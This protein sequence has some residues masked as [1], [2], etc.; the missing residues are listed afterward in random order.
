MP[1]KNGLQL[2]PETRRKIEVKVPG[3]NRTVYAGIAVL[4]LVVAA[5]AGLY[6]FGNS[7]GN[8]II[9]LD[10][11]LNNL[12]NQRDKKAEANLLVLDKQLS[13]ISVLLN[14]HIYWSK[15]MAKVESLLQGQV[16]FENLAAATPDSKF[17]FKALAAN[18]TTIARQIAAFMSDES[19]KDVVLNNVNTLTN[20]KL[21]FNMQI[22]F[23]K[24]K[25]LK[26]K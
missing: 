24:A 8:K 14:D 1:D 25:F 17:D 4:V 26:Q 19:I 21:E 6:F 13:L 23:D 12:E 7:L 10:G 22:T 2:L 15:A 5:A 16:Q 9:G 3:E 11:E 18:Y 20:G